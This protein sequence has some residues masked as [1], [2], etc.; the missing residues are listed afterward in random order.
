M[1]G[2]IV[3][4]IKSSYY[5]ALLSTSEAVLGV[6]IWLWGPQFKGDVEKL[7]ATEQATHLQIQKLSGEVADFGEHISAMD[8]LH[9]L[10]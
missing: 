6:H 4:Q 3:K 7:A 10:L 8:S 2:E 1:V 5:P 9:L